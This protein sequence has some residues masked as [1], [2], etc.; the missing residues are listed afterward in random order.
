[1][2]SCYSSCGSQSLKLFLSGQQRHLAIRVVDLNPLNYFF[3]ASCAIVLLKQQILIS[4]IASFG[5]TTSL[6]V[7]GLVISFQCHYYDLLW[8]SVPRFSLIRGQQCLSFNSGGDFS[9]SKSCLTLILTLVYLNFGGNIPIRMPYVKYED[10]SIVSNTRWPSNRIKRA[11]LREFS[12][13]AV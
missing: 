6:C 3:R 7:A 1:V 5:I 10:K 13:P 11:L 9:S 4:R 8:A 2:P 12:I